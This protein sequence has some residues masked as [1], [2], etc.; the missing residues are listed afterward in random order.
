MG[1][2]D[3][4]ER[5][6]RAVTTNAAGS[7]QRPRPPRPRS[8]LDHEGQCPAIQRTRHVQTAPPVLFAPFLEGGTVFSTTSSDGTRIAFDGVG[9]GP[10]LVL[11]DGALCH[12][13]FG[14]SQKIAAEL[15]A[16]FTVYTYDRR[17]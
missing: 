15:A 11:V 9:E 3:S 6:R 10:A 1:D 5:T 14:S 4:G 12:R 2:K 7:D 8:K 13:G 17:G 16:E